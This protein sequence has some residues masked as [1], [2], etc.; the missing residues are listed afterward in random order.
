MLYMKE[1]CVTA[2]MKRSR[3]A[4][5]HEK[6]LEILQFSFEIVSLRYQEKMSDFMGCFLGRYM[7]TFFVLSF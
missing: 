6:S 1:R 4:A 7:A 5:L 2:D 3:F